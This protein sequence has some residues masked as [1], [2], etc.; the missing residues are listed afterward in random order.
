MVWLNNVQN[1]LLV[2][3]LQQSSIPYFLNLTRFQNIRSWYDNRCSKRAN[4][5][6]IRATLIK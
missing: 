4:K 6:A 5:G 2:Q 1:V 3:L